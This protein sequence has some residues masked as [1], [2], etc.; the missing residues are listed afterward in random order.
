M[1]GLASAQLIVKPNIAFNVATAANLNNGSWTTYDYVSGKTIIDLNPYGEAKYKL[2]VSNNS[3]QN[4]NGYKA[5]IPIPKAGQNAGSDFQQQ[6]FEWDVLLNNPIDVSSTNYAYTVRYSTTY[7]NN[8]DDVSWKTWNEITDK[9]TIKAVRIVTTDVIPDGGQ[10]EITFTIDMDPATADTQA[11][12]TNIYTA[13]IK[14]DLGGIVANVPSEPVAIRLKTGVIKGQVFND[15][16]R[17]GLLNGT[18]TGLNGVVVTAYEAGTTTVLETKT[19]QTL[20]GVPGSYAF[21]GLDKNQNVDIVFTNPTNDDSIRFSAVTSGGSTPTASATHD[22]ATTSNLTPSAVGFDSIDAGFITPITVTF[23]GNTGVSSIASTKKYPGE[24]VSPT[25][26]ATKVGHTFNGWFTA[27]TGGS[28]V[29][30][31]YTVGAADVTLY[32]QYTANKYVLSYDVATNGATSTKPAD[33]QVTFDTLATKPADAVKTGYTFTGWFTAATG[34]TQWNFATSKMPAN[35]VQLYAQFTINSYTMTFDNDGATT[36]Q[37]VVYDTLATEPTAPTKTGFTFAGWFDAQT[38]GTKWNF[39]TNKMPASNKTLYA[40]YT[41]NNYTL[42]FNDQGTTSTQT[43]A[44]DAL[45]VEPATVP[46]KSGYTFSGWF[47]AATAGTKWNFATSKMPASNKTLYAQ[48]TADDQTITFDVN[49]GLGTSKPANL[50]QPTDSSVDLDAVAIPTRAGYTFV[51]WFDSAD[52]QH[53]GTFTMPVGGLSLKAKWTADDQVISFNTKG[54]TGVASITAKTDTTV[55]L[56]TVSTTRPGYQ[57]DGWYVGSTQYTGVT[58]VPAGGL[59]LE[60]HWTALDQTITFDVNGGNA[61]TQPADIIQV[62]DSTVNLNT[63]T[64]PTWFGHKFLGW[65]DAADTSYSGTITM[66]AGGLNLIADWQDLIADGVWR[67]EGDNIRISV[68]DLKTIVANGTLEDEILAR[69]NAKAWNDA[70]LEELH[71]L[72]VDTTELLSKATVGTYQVKIS[73]EEQNQVA[74]TLFN[75]LA[76]SELNTTINVEVFDNTETTLPAT[77][78]NYMELFGLGVGIVSLGGLVVLIKRFKLKK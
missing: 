21:L 10:D 49:G 40:Q 44:F 18:E 70:T 75:E 50:V 31:P 62:T 46:T 3:G 25:P 1:S 8:F 64:A 73:H 36:T 14:R 15:T 53:S 54:G 22:K 74:A 59:A 5:I 29:T 9:T 7:T 47:D 11:G 69:S 65:K 51:G 55:D 77:G 61:T 60:A 24:A 35:A 6:N 71:P 33:E 63:V 28:K 72:M 27:S 16:D 78:Q 58:T 38:G 66:P 34:G 42:T 57:F 48:F 17:N 4:I 76:T 56:D 30:F 67:I 52:T 13:L 32:A 20:N 45:V 12:G 43:V 37:T 19:T 41:R 2:S 26:T 68:N 23:N 39:A